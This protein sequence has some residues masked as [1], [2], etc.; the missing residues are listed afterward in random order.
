MTASD[1]C[2]RRGDGWC[3]GPP[4]PAS[5]NNSEAVGGPWPVDAVMLFDVETGRNA[6]APAFAQEILVTKAEIEE[7][8]VAIADL[9]ALR[10]LDQ[11]FLLGNQVIFV[12]FLCFLKFLD[13]VMFFLMVP[14]SMIFVSYV[15]H[16]VLESLEPPGDAPR[17]PV[18]QKC[19]ERQF[20]ERS[21]W[22]FE[23]RLT[24]G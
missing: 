14:K 2:D 17:S 3:T 6:D 11:S 12:Q 8:H 18:L 13:I 19:R 20:P 21:I 10:E 4:C 22:N 7:K 1:P 16:P 9:D 24:G 15:L 23:N 5:H